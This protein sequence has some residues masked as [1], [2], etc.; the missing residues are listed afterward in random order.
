LCL[1]AMRMT[2]EALM[3]LKPPG[4]EKGLKPP[5][6]L[7]GGAGILEMT[8]LSTCDQR[9]YLGLLFAWLSYNV[10]REFV[11]FIFIFPT[12]SSSDFHH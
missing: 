1:V 5:M 4:R 12:L 11:V 10:K 2:V 8:V 7:R 9:G 3:Y 6:Q